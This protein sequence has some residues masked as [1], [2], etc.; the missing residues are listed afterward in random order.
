MSERDATPQAR[1]PL[2][3]VTYAI[4]LVSAVIL[5][6]A[7]ALLITADAGLR[8]MFNAPISWAQDLAGLLLFVLFAAG[9]THSMA[10][11]AHVRMDLIYDLLPAR[12][13]QAV[14]VVSAAAALLFSVVLAYQAIPSTITN[15]RNSSMMPTGEI[16]IWPFAALGSFCL[17]IFGLSV[18]VR[19]VRGIWSAR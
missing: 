14:D 16:I 13:R 15:W 4:F 18:F 19:I 5:L 1:S 8:Y 11:N 9:L 17:L 2:D 7:I 10:L 12:V 6:P 3:R